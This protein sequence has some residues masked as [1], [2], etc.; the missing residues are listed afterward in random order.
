[1]VC[2]AMLM[3]AVE[4]GLLKSPKDKEKETLM[5]YAYI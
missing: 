5:F 2:G 1:M 4:Q 3:E